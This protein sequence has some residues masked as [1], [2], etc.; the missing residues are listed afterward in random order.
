MIVEFRDSDRMLGVKAI[1]IYRKSI[2]AA[3]AACEK[4]Y[5]PTVE[6]QTADHDAEVASKWIA[7][8]LDEMGIGET[9]ELT[10]GAELALA[11]RMATSCYLVSLSKLSEK[12]ADLLVPLEDTNEIMSRLRSLSDRLSGQ[13]EMAGV[14]TMT[15]TGTGINTGPITMDD[16]DKATR[17]LRKKSRS[18]T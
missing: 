11:L 6:L 18:E 12:Q 17:R 5:V 7:E 9:R 14:T 1:G 15:I 13:M 4:V 8:S 10:I 2:E 16:M 3:V